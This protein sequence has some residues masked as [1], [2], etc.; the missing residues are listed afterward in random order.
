MPEIQ[1]ELNFRWML[2]LVSLLSC[3]MVQSN[4]A[5]KDTTTIAVAAFIQSNDIM[6]ALKELPDDTDQGESDGQDL[7]I[8]K[9]SPTEL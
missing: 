5:L 8:D 6:K 9:S 4:I 2:L 3:M 1:Q 7:S